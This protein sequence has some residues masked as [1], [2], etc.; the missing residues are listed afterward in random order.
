MWHKCDHR[1]NEYCLNNDLHH[2]NIAVSLS[3]VVGA[4]PTLL[5]FVHLRLSAKHQLHFFIGPTFS[6][7]VVLPADVAT[8]GVSSPRAS[9]ISS[10]VRGNSCSRVRWS[11]FTVT[12]HWCSFPMASA[13]AKLQQRM[14]TH[15]EACVYV[16]SFM[17]QW[18]VRSLCKTVAYRCEWLKGLNKS[19]SG[20]SDKWDK[21]SGVKLLTATA[22]R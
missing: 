10:E 22:V 17:C 4:F 16:Y 1:I 6:V 14:I 20:R 12:T 7:H 18:Q 5:G 21:K 15:F 19:S 3:N 8:G 9:P 2:R 13:G 11:W